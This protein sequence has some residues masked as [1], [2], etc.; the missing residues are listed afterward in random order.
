VREIIRSIKEKM[1][2]AEHHFPA[3]MEKA[4]SSSEIEKTYEMSDGV[5]LAIENQRFRCPETFF[6]P[7]QIQLE[8]TGIPEKILLSIMKCD[9]EISKDF[10]VHIAL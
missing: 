7:N 8:G 5:I 1:S 9:I 2:Y 10:Y 4:A 6:Q 3:G